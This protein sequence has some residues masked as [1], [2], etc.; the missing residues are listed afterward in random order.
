M[1]L[2][3]MVV[4]GK[5]IQM[6]ESEIKTLAF[7]QSFHRP[8]GVRTSDLQRQVCLPFLITLHTALKPRTREV[9]PAAAWNRC[10]AAGEA[11]CA[12]CRRVRDVGVRVS[13][14]L[15]ASASLGLLGGAIFAQHAFQAQ[16]CFLLELTGREGNRHGVLCVTGVRQ[17][18]WWRCFL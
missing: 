11:I 8:G 14:W 4:Q 9:S 10:A 18:N 5:I 3:C 16:L 1:M 13:D 17:G 12:V 15:L 7:M 6:L 2:S